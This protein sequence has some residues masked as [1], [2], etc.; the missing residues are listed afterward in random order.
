M[1]DSKVPTSDMLSQIKSEYE[2][3]IDS[4]KQKLSDAAKKHACLVYLCQQKRAKKKR[5]IPPLKPDPACTDFASGDPCMAITDTQG[6]MDEARR[7]MVQASTQRDSALN[8]L[9]AYNATDGSL[10][11]LLPDVDQRIEQ[12]K[13]ELDNAPNPIPPAAAEANG[14]GQLTKQ[15]IEENWMSFTFDSEQS[16]KSVDT[17]SKTYKAAL[18]F[19]GGGL[20][21]SVSGG[22]SYSRSSQEFNQKMS[23]SD[24]DISAKFLRVTFTRNWFRPSLFNMGKLK[25]VSSYYCHCRDGYHTI[26]IVQYLY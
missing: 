11:S 23:N 15:E 24:V 3:T 19:S 10:K 18:S 12:L 1:I 26:K 22:T 17:E 20:L 14:T 21:W 13:N 8:Q 2:D 16:T 9:M 4:A 7:A 5:K 25:L 6:A